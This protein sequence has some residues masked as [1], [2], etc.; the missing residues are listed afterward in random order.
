VLKLTATV[1]SGNTPVAVGQVN[2]CDA[3]ATACAD[4]HLLGTSQLTS[5][6]TASL[7]FTPGVGSHS[8][9]PVFA[10]T[11]NGN[12]K[13]GGSASSAV[14]LSVTAMLPSATTITAAG[15][16]GNYTLTSSVTASGSA[17]SLAGAVSFLDTSNANF[18]LGMAPLVAGTPQLNFVNSS[19][20]RAGDLAWSVAVGDFNGDG[21]PDFVVANYGD[22]TVSVLLGKGDGTFTP[23]PN[24]PFAVTYDALSIVVADFNG[25]GKLDV[26]MEN[27]YYNGVVSIFLGNGDGTF[28]SA[29]NSPITVGGPFIQPGAVVAGDFNGDGIPDLVATNAQYVPNIPSTMTVLLGKGDGTFTPAPNSS[30]S[31]GSAPISIAAG[32]FNGDGVP[33]LAMVDFYGNTEIILLGTGNGTFTAAKNSPIAVGTEPAGVAIGGFNGDGILDLAVAN[34]AYT[35][36]S[37]GSVTVLLGN[38]DGTFTPA[39]NSPVT[40]GANPR[41][42]AVGDFNRDGNLDLAVANQNDDTV[43]IL[44]GSGNGQFAPAAASPLMV[45]DFPQSTAVADFNGDGISDIAVVN[46]GTSNTTVFLSQLTQTAAATVSGI[47]ALGSGP[48]LVEASYAGGADYAGSISQTVSLV[49]SS[50]TVAGTVVS[51]SPGA[52]TGNTSSITVSPTGGFTGSVVMTAAITASPAG[53]QNLPT[54]R[55]A[56]TSPVSISGASAA[57]ATL[58]ILTTAPGSAALVV[59]GSSPRSWYAAGISA[60]AFLFLVSIPAPGRSARTTIALLVLLVALTA[61]LSG[62][63]GSGGGGGGGNPGTTPGTYTITVTGTSGN[64]T[65]TGAVTL[66]VQ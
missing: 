53:A 56:S 32:D 51:L 41:S 66:T 50:F 18:S 39:A 40:V 27:G 38:G 47:S 34:C 14:A 9:K 17:V 62:C 20:P 22:G 64:A 43:T 61:G 24:S 23:A 6:G 33:D 49:G 11:P 19:T 15:S 26:A 54:F 1:N 28:T 31:V 2:F 58:T 45:G 37:P 13:F 8:Y 57:T 60:L 12:P 16:P 59:P 46:Y 7:K 42:L 5:S 55:F 63:G 3:S 10:G 21:I 4:I 44:L 48:H 35:I 25:D 30:V 36:G 52:T 29:A 65:A